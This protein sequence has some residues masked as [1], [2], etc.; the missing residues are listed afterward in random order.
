[1][2]AGS[3]KKFI[4]AGAQIRLSHITSQPTDIAEGGEE[5]ESYCECRRPAA[6][7]HCAAHYSSCLELSSGLRPEDMLLRRS[8]RGLLLV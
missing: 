7:C 2:A 6:G 3:P 1:M 5:N 4:L 8:Q